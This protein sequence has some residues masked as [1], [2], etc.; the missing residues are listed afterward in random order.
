[1][2]GRSRPPV[3][4]RAP[5]E[6]ASSMWA[7]TL[8]FWSALTRLPMSAPQCRPGRQPHPGHLLDEPRHELVVDVGVHDEPL[9]ADAELAGRREA[10][11][12]GTRDGPAQVGVGGDVHGV[13]A[14]ELEADADEALAGRLGHPAAGGG[15]PGEADVVGEVDD[16]LP[17][18][19]TVAEH[20]L[21]HVLGQP[22]VLE[23]LGGRQGGQRPLQVGA[24]HDRVAGQQGGDG[25]GDGQ[26]QRVVP[27]RDD[28]DDAL[29][30][31][32]LHGPR[33]HG[34]HAHVLG[35]AQERR[36]APGVV[37]RHDRAVGDLLVR[38]RAGLARLELHEVEQLALPV[39]HQVVHA[40]QHRGALLDRGRPPRLRWAP[41]AL[42][43]ATPTSWAVD[44]GST[45]RGAPVIGVRVTAS[46][47]SPAATTRA[48]SARTRAGS[49]AYVARG[50]VSGSATT[51]AITEG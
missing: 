6:T 41:R 23:D 7:S 35:L 8:A 33:Q 42:S 25:V 29:G 14:A 9:G 31:V 11:A 45:A 32:V 36:A 1:M 39:E 37:A 30:P 51:S 50:S 5:L 20:D 18:G 49:T 12:H 48:V 21:Q 17:G 2:S 19:V 27:R 13:L 44:S 22:G 10:G 28:A 24:Q 3:S 40:Q 47:P 4:T 43:T 26:A 34:Q 15:R 16:G 46:P 38:V